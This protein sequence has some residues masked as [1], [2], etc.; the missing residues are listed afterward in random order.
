MKQHFQFLILSLQCLQLY[1]KV[2]PVLSSIIDEPVEIEFFVSVGIKNFWFIQTGNLLVS[3]G[4]ALQKVE[5]VIIHGLKG[6]E[7]AFFVKEV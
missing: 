3:L 4:H 7:F 6:S 2:F 1:R 5:T